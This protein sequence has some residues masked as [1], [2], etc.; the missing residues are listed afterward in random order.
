MIPALGDQGAADL[1]RELARHTMDWAKDLASSCGVAI[2]V[3]YT[4]G[5]EE[6]IRAEFPS[7]FTY[8]PQAEGDL[9]DRLRE[10]FSTAFSEGAESVIAV[11]TDCPDLDAGKVAAAFETLQKHAV[12][13]GPSSDGGYYLIGMACHSPRLFEDMPWS[14]ESLY[15]ATMQRIG[16]GKLTVGELEVLDDVDRPE[17]LEVW[18]RVQ[19]S[20]FS[21]DGDKPTGEVLSVIIPTLE[22]AD[23][24]ET[25]LAQFRN[26]LGIEIIVVEG[27]EETASR[28]VA[29]RYG[30]RWIQA[31]RGRGKQMNAGA[32]VAR[33]ETLLFLHADTRLPEGFQTTVCETLAPSNVAL[34]AFKLKIDGESRS[35]RLIERWADHRS[36]WLGLPY[37]DQAFFLKRDKFKSLDGFREI[38]IMEDFDLARRARKKGRIAIASTAVST[39]ARR[40]KRVGPWRNTI[41]NQWIVFC[42][43]IGVSPKRLASWY[44]RK[45]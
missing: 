30:A 2:Q 45:A 18:N 35:L 41:L 17:D 28:V 6:E 44:G 21:N 31:S 12:V 29:D 34:G 39:S 5:S 22:A 24:L 20:R 13:I 43:Q 40:W 9:G 25:C 38:E 19:A 36:R 8:L 4:G 33:C 10:G 11:G 16:E 15:A 1:H 32:K 27:G 42:Y 23:V 14:Q 37:G 7:E 3:V 26:A